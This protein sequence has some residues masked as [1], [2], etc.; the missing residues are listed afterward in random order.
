MTSS[1]RDLLVLFM[2]G[3]VFGSLGD[4]THVLTGT[5]TY[6]PLVYGIYF[7]GLLPYWV[8]L[9]FGTAGIAIGASHPWAD[10]WLGGGTRPGTRTWGLVA[11]GSSAFL[12]L[13]ALS[14]WLPR[15]S[16][17]IASVVLA[18]GALGLW[19]WLDRTWQGL[20]LAAATALVGTA[21]EVMLIRRGIFA[22]RPQLSGLAGAAPWLPWLYVAASV[23]VGN[24]GRKLQQTGEGGLAP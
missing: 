4:L 8:P 10:R 3:A 18:A 5:T 9:L 24:L 14:G 19:I 13:D 15:D 21:F 12:G 7:F 22:Y 16:L 20:V 17:G 2:V 1:S 23:A 11:A 6:P